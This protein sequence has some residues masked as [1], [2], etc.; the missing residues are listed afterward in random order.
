MHISAYYL[1][2][3]GSIFINLYLHMLQS[4]KTAYTVIPWKLFLVAVNDQKLKDISIDIL[5]IFYTLNHVRP[6]CT[7]PTR[8]TYNQYKIYVIS[9]L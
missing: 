1:P 6:F 3:L 8:V 9:F 7:P 2:M 4:D 5:F